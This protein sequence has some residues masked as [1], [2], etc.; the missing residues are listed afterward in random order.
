MTKLGYTR[1]K[2][3]G[4][5]DCKKGI[6]QCPYK[7]EDLQSEWSHGFD[8]AYDENKSHTMQNLDKIKPVI[9]E[10]VFNHITSLNKAELLVMKK[11][12]DLEIS[13]VVSRVY[14]A[15]SNE[16]YQKLVFEANLLS[17]LLSKP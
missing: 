13:N 14:A 16:Y 9:G 6:T 10:V 15:P 12:K 3:R 17:Y 1:A 4:Y 7:N 8:K 2:T 5:N 11:A